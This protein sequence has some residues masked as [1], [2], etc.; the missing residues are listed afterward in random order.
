MLREQKWK[1]QFLSL[2]VSYWEQI[3]KIRNRF[4]HIIIMKRNRIAQL[5]DTWEEEKKKLI[6]A[7]EEE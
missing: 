5:R 3:L 7:Y 2:G 4:L 6:V 1:N